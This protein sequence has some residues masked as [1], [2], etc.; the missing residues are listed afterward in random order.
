MFRSS[1]KSSQP[2]TDDEVERSVADDQAA[3]PQRQQRL[4][5]AARIA[6]YVV[7]PAVAL[8]LTLAAGWFK[9]QS[10][11]TGDVDLARI[12]S[13]Q[14]A[15]DATVAIL[16]YQP[17]TVEKQL[18]AARDRLTGQFRDSYNSLTQEVVIPGAKQKQV[19]AVANVA[20]AAPLSTSRAHAVVLLFVNQTV[21]MRNDTPTNTTSSVQVTLD[22]IDNRWLVSG[23]DPV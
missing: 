9:W 13:M 10:G 11:I 15:T 7:L 22:K 14:A 8:M 16:S 19:S 2:E 23:F 6:G 18:V 5:L 21:T 17:D 20:A 3:Q 12:Q 4:T 1:R